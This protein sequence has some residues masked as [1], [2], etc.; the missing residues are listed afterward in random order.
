MPL[1]AR[2]VQQLTWASPAIVYLKLS[3]IVPTYIVEAIPLIVCKTRLESED[4]NNGADETTSFFLALNNF[5]NLFL[6]ASIWWK[7][8]CIPKK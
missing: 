1:V 2:S 6:A 5:C 3:I 7:C 8:I 4:T